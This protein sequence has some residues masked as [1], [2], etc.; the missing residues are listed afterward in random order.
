MQPKER[1]TCL[2]VTML[3]ERSGPGATTVLLA[4]SKWWFERFIQ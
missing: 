4:E 3:F 2:E 1:F